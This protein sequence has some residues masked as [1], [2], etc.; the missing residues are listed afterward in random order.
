MDIIIDQQDNEQQK[1]IQEVNLLEK[2]KLKCVIVGCGAVFTKPSCF[3]AH[4]RV[5]VNDVC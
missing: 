2:K 4:L 3:Q 5:H 1:N